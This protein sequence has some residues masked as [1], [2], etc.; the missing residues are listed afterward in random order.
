MLSDRRVFLQQ[1]LGVTCAAFIGRQ[2]V[3]PFLQSPA[4]QVASG[5]SGTGLIERMTW[6]NPPAS[7]SE[8]AGRLVAR[9]RPKTDF[10]RTTLT[11]SILDNGHF[12][13]LPVDGAFTFQ[14]RINGQCA[15]EFDQAGLMVRLDANNWMKCGTELFQGRRQASV[16]FTRDFS[17]WSIMPYPS[18][19]A[20]VWWRAARSKNSIEVSW[21]LDGKTFRLVRSG[22]FPPRARANAGI[23]CAAPTGP[24]FEAVFDELKLDIG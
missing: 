7:F 22:Y 6:M 20:D 19:S 14:A 18:H 13:S 21:S 17:D 12:F 10:W 8:S 16:V 1:S 2:T 9:S 4:G 11:G 23:M 3:F 24:G 15:A 5:A